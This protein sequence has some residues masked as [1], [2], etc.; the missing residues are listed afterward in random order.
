MEVDK[1]MRAMVLEY[2]RAV[3]KRFKLSLTD[4]LSVYH[5]AEPEVK[6]AKRTPKKKATK[7]TA[8]ASLVRSFYDLPDIKY[9]EKN[10]Y[11]IHTDTRFII[12][13]ERSR[14][15]VIGKELDGMVEPL[16][17]KDVERCKELHLQYNLPLT[18]RET[19]YQSQKKDIHETMEEI[20]SRLR[21]GDGTE[22][23]D[24]LSENEEEDA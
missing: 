17:N 1:I 2:L 6:K 3:S 21:K 9:T 20:Y 11:L 12:Q 22:T 4:V 24:D 18:L 16:T 19:S 14:F 8:P 10:G 7:K 13:P 5:G 23:P 15:V